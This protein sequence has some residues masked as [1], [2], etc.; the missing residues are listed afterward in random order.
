MSTHLDPEVSARLMR[1]TETAPWLEW[2]DRADPILKEPLALRNGRL[3][4]PDRP[5]IGLEWGEAAV[6]ATVGRF[7]RSRARDR[8]LT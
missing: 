5:G 3:V 2:Q 4:V 1:V 8:P 6:A 7:A